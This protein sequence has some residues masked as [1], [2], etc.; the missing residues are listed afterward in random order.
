MHLSDITNAAGTAVTASLPPGPATAELRA[1]AG[2][3]ATECAAAVGVSERTWL[4][5]EQGV[6][7]SFRRHESHLRAA[8]VVA[9]LA[10]AEGATA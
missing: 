10:D 8:R 3:T 6:T 7:G 9:H 2:L 1:R 4:R 5:Y